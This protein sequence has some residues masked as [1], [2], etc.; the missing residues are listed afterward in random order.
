MNKTPW[1]GEVARCHACVRA[2]ELLSPALGDLLMTFSYGVPRVSGGQPVEVADCADRR[3]S[4]GL[5]SFVCRCR[6]E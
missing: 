1:R 2:A 4:S 5:P 3:C 6:V